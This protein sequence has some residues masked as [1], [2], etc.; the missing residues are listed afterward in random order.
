MLK[1]SLRKDGL[2]VYTSSMVKDPEDSFLSDL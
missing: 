1:E 2:A